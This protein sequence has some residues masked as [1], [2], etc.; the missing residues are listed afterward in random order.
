MSR[1]ER[2]HK[3][4]QWLRGGHGVVH[5]QALRDLEVSS[6]TLHR[7]FAYMR[8]RLG[9]PVRWLPAER[10]WRMDSSEAMAGEQYELPGLWFSAEEIHFSG[11]GH[12]LVATPS[13]A[14]PLSSQ[15]QPGVGS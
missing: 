11:L 10:V 8:D 14:H 6:S 1:Q 7:D 13:P 3:L 9:M 4:G 2:L 15:G 12:G 5:A